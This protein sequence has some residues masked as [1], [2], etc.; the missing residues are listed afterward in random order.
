MNV[1]YS[2]YEGWEVKGKVET[3]LLR[4]KIA[5]DKGEKKIEKGF[6]EFVKRGKVSKIV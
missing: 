5:I 4:G 2:A 6:G 3:V 1:D